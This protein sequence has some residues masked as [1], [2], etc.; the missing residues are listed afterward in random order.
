MKKYTIILSILITVL[1][2]FAQH[3]IVN[4]DSVYA[5]LSSTF[6]KI[7]DKQSYNLTTGLMNKHFLMTVGLTNVELKQW[8]DVI[9]DSTGNR[10]Q[11]YHR[12]KTML[13]CSIGYILK[14]L[15]SNSPITLGIIASFGIGNGFYI[16]S[17]GM[18]FI[19]RIKIK[20]VSIFPGFGFNINFEPGD[21]H[22]R[23]TN[24]TFFQSYYPKYHKKNRNYPSFY[25]TCSTNLKIFDKKFTIN[26]CQTIDKSPNFQIGMSFLDILTK[27]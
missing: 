4:E 20:N 9:S 11:T 2:I 22:S 27:N 1:P 5:S 15:K 13:T 14:D 3:I 25:Y 12:R 19:R 21:H 8:S 7:K 10:V 24:T 26:V 23:A 16:P 17:V 18:Q 6:I